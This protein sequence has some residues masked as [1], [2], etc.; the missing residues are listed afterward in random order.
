MLFLGFASLTAIIIKVLPQ[1][2]HILVIFLRSRL[3]LVFGIHLHLSG[4]LPLWWRPRYNYA[5]IRLQA[6]LSMERRLVVRAWLSRRRLLKKV[7][8]TYGPRS[9]FLQSAILDG[10]EFLQQGALR[11]TEQLVY[12]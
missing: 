7:V 3:L 12:Q 9:G 6:H 8:W 2:I 10:A 11:I 5:L 1:L 4:S